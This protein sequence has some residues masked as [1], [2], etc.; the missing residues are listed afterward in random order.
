MAAA[1]ALIAAAPAPRAADTVHVSKSE[2]TTFAFAFLDIGIKEGIFAKH[3]LDVVGVNLAG[4]AKAHQA[5]VAGS[6]DI[7]VGS[8]VEFIYIAHG[9]PAKGIA[10][11]AGPPFG[12][13]IMVRDPAIKSLADLK[14]KL[15]GV[16]TM[17]S[18]SDWLATEVSRRQ[19]WGSDGLKRA[20]LGDQS[21]L[22]AGL[23][24]GNVDAIIGGMQ[25]AYR[26]ED[27]G[28]GRALTNFGPLIPDFITHMIVASDTF[29]AAHPNDVRRFLAAWFETV[30]FAKANRDAA[31]RDTMPLTGLP[32]E[33][34]ASIYDQQISMM[35]DDGR[36]GAKQLEVTKQA[37]RDLGNIEQLPPDNALFTEAFLP[38]RDSSKP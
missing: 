14:G 27:S 4:A 8:G 37:V 32:S 33:P 30:R 18:L 23:V 25:T 29:I 36:F 35:S 24:S 38:P 19:G 7:E 3:D 15:V 31:I 1:A 5:L 17:G 10:V 2:G 13:G 6:V 16:S 22:T 28:R 21:A 26:L 20:A 9:S 12:L 11:L 34:A